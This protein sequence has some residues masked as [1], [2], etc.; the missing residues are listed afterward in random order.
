M[1]GKKWSFYADMVAS[2]M[3]MVTVGV[4]CLQE[5]GDVY[6]DDDCSIRMLQQYVK[7]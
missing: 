6:S 3:G 2:C 4:F 1:G 7:L 5:E